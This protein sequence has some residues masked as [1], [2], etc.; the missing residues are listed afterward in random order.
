MWNP[1]VRQVVSPDS[2][3]GL[4]VQLLQL[5]NFWNSK[6]ISSIGEVRKKEVYVILKLSLDIGHNM[7]SQRDN[8]NSTDIEHRI[9]INREHCILFKLNAIV[10]SSLGRRQGRILGSMMSP[11]LR[12][13]PIFRYP[14]DFQIFN[15]PVK[16]LTLKS[17]ERRS[18]HRF[19]IC[20]NNI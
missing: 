15:V 8:I 12:H 3:Q 6:Y 17:D 4:P 10:P 16:S 20:K 2:Q 18:R 14:S 7:I 1:I 19:S 9:N 11:S 13:T 5:G